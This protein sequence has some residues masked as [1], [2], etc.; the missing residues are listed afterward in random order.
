MRIFS[1]RS[2]VLQCL[3]FSLLFMAVI[4]FHS[5]IWPMPN[6]HAQWLVSQNL[7][8]VAFP[9]PYA[10]YL[11]GNYL[12]PALFGIFGGGSLDAYFAYSIAVSFLFIFVVIYWFLTY[13]GN[14]SAIEESR[15]FVLLA[16]PFIFIPFYWVGIDGM[17]LLLMAAVLITFN[18]KILPLFFGFLLGLQHFEQGFL[19]FAVLGGSV[20]LYFL[21]H[22]DKALV[23]DIW[24]LL[25][26]GAAIFLGKLAL[27]SF[28]LAVGVELQGD[29]V[30][31]LQKHIQ[32]YYEDWT[33]KWPF[34][35]WS[36]L[37][38]SWVL[39]VNNIRRY[40]TFLLA[41]AFI[42]VF[43][44][45]V[46]DQTRVGIILIFPSV[47]Y[48]VLRDRELWSSLKPR[49]V[50]YLSI[51]PLALPVVVVWGSVHG[52]L[53]EDSS[54]LVEKA[55][56]GQGFSLF[57]VDTVAPFSSS[58]EEGGSVSTEPLESYAFGLEM[59][60]DFLE[61][62]AGESIS[63]SVKLHNVSE[64]TWP[65]GSTANYNVNFSYKI[66]DKHGEFI[67]PD[68]HR[69]PLPHDVDPGIDVFLD[70]MISAQGLAPG[71]YTVIPDLVHERIRWFGGSS[72]Q[73]KLKLVVVD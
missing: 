38:V 30:T 70:V 32:Y 44:M 73:V 33:N 62:S 20:L 58:G 10:H 16:F 26:L 42:I 65:G 27:A 9:D 23:K 53:Y 6:I 21:V 41:T 50:L 31:Y 46:G 19:S 72:E 71:E 18:R 3:F 8:S 40:W 25:A 35:A 59:P 12:M 17:T 49:A 45:L 11:Y 28:L 68:G 61:V 51:L 48:W 37:G 13:H 54:R 67:V 5:G 69:T 64:S 14:A 34:I 56:S 57:D 1:N 15:L 52:S 60:V 24:K 43:L 29:R 55:L 2:L 22:K 4:F 39:V 66:L 63:L 36:L 47:F 7:T